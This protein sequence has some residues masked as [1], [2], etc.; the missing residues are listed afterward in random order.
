MTALK[1]TRAGRRQL[2]EAADQWNRI[3]LAMARAL[4]A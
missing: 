2:G 4:E 3:A 1:L